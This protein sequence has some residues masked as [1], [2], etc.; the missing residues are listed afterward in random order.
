MEFLVEYL[1]ELN[2]EEV[3]QKKGKEKKTKKQFNFEEKKELC[4][5]VELHPAI[6]KL[7]HKGHSNTEEVN[8]NWRS[9]AGEMCKTIEECRVA[10]KSLRDSLRYHSV[11]KKKQKSGSAA[12]ADLNEENLSEES[13]IDWEFAEYLSFLTPISSKRKTFSSTHE[14]E[15]VDGDHQDNQMENETSTSSYSF[16]PKP[17]KKDTMI[18]N[19]S[20]LTQTVTDLINMRKNE[21]PNTQ[22]LTH[23]TLLANLDRILKELPNDVVEELGLNFQQQAF[24]ELRKLRRS[25]S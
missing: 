20:A 24:A 16:S 2:P 10:W 14:V 11:A 6:W 12:N 1:D 22:P 21:V 23:F 19:V 4:R 15:V 13:C 25:G 7:Q 18:E 5:L 9:I 8:S 3:P 17:Q